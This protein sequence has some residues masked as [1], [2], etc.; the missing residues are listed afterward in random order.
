V[1]WLEEVCDDNCAVAIEGGERVDC[2]DDC[3]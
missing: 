2:D 1:G 3:E